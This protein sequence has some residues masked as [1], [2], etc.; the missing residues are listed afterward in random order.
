VKR[1][2]NEMSVAGYIVIGIVILFLLLMYVLI[3]IAYVGYSKAYKEAVKT[4]ATIL[5]D[6][7]DMKMA[8]GSLAI[9]V[10]RFR[11]FHK[12]KVSYFADGVE[13]TEE[14]E[15]RK[16]TLNV[17]DVTEVR[18]NVSKKGKVSLESEAFLCWSREMA[19]GYTIGLILGVILSVLK[20]NDV[21]E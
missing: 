8:T 17:G 18:Y 21:I 9:G 6:L 16:K 3:L 15:L 19:I 10:P 20:I 1:K 7:G 5:E 13:Y 12:Y 4:Q 2:E 14:A 11:T